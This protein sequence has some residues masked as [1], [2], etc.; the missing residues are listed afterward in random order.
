MSAA[1]VPAAIAVFVLDTPGIRAWAV[2][3]AA[4]IPLA[5]AWTLRVGV[6]CS[7]RT[8]HVYGF[9][10]TT[11]VPASATIEV[12]SRPSPQMLW[13]EMPGRTRSTPLQGFWAGPET[14]HAVHNHTITELARLRAW[15][16]ANR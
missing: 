11:H 12:T 9:L 15:I 3:P 4:L 13:R 2:V 7:R 8:V 16:A 5:L 6:R 1:M 14:H 10:A